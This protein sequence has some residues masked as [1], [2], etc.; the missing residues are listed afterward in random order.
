MGPEQLGICGLVDQR[1]EAVVTRG[2]VAHLDVLLQ[3]SGGR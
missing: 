3:E 2:A 1:T